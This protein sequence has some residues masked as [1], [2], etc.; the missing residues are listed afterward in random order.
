MLIALI[1]VIPE[2]VEFAIDEVSESRPHNL[3]NVYDYKGE[4]LVCR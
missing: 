2:N 1:F 3:H 4:N